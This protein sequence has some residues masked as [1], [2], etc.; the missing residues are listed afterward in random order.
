M[1]RVPWWN[2]NPR[3]WVNPPKPVCPATTAGTTTNDRGDNMPTHY[4]NFHTGRSR[5]GV[6]SMRRRSAARRHVHGWLRYR[7]RI[8]VNVWSTRH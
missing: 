1:H 7:E 6:A 2:H 5:G 8:Q 3:T 4:R